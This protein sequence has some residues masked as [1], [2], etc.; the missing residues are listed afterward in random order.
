MFACLLLYLPAFD[1]KS[2][3]ETDVEKIADSILNT[4]K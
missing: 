1:E 4:Y 2:L 3:W